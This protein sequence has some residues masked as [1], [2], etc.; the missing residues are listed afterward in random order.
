MSRRSRV[1]TIVA[2]LAITAALALPAS[3]ALAGG[4]PVATK[5][6]AIVNYVSTAKVK[7]GKRSGPSFVCSVTCNLTSN[8][9]LKG[10]H[11]KLPDT[12]SAT[13]VPP[14]QGLTH[15]FNFSKFPKPV[16]QF[17][18]Q[19]VGQYKLVSTVSA[20][21]ATSGATDAISHVFKLKR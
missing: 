1:G 21:D 12:K 11:V 6:G 8:L 4:G 14:G 17:I 5:S 13:N 7:F 9:V 19:H 2:A 20:T 3:N 10:P 15:F 18:A 16:R